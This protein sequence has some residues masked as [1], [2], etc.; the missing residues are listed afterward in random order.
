[1]GGVIGM[2]RILGQP[3]SSSEDSTHGLSDIG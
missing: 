3:A 2:V 1:M